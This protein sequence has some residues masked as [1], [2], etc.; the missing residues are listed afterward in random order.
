MGKGEKVRPVLA[1][2]WKSVSRI[3]TDEALV[4]KTLD[5]QKGFFWLCIDPNGRERAK[6]PVTSSLWGGGPAPGYWHDSRDFLFLSVNGLSCFN[7]ITRQEQL[8]IPVD[9]E[10]HY[11]WEAQFSPAKSPRVLYLLGELEEPRS[12]IREKASA[13]SV[14]GEVRMRSRCLYL[15]TLKSRESR[16]VIKF[17]AHIGSLAVDW[18]RGVAFAFIGL[19]RTKDLVKIS[20][21][22]NRVEVIRT[23]DVA[24]SVAISPKGT[25]LTWRQHSAPRIMETSAD[26]K[27]VPFTQFGWHPAFSPDG[28]RFAFTVEDYALWLQ[29]GEQADP[30]KIVSFSPES[31]HHALDRPTWCPCGNHFAI[32]LAGG[33]ADGTD[34]R[35]LIIADCKR[36]EILMCEDLISIGT[37]G[38][39]AWVPGGV[40][41][42]YFE[43]SVA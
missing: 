2:G 23:T 26:G 35:P 12:R 43:T 5:D 24:D 29:D 31:T 1:K 22:T 13:S 17:E 28:K 15:W 10:H 6:L 14:G 30:E 21:K 36:K 20:L 37:K 33:S 34:H 4:A 40:A 11:W 38:E 25:L 9:L 8:L 42:A 16:L 7:M 27:E 41:G 3:S 39:R 19:Q 18:G 32:C